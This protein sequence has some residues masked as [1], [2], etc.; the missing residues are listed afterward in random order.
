MILE[1]SAYVSI[2]F[3]LLPHL[4]F[5]WPSIRLNAWLIVVVRSLCVEGARTATVQELTCSE[6]LAAEAENQV[7]WGPVSLGWGIHSSP[8]DYS[9]QSH[10]GD[11]KLKSLGLTPR[12][13]DI[14]HILP[15]T[16][17]FRGS[18]FKNTAPP[19]GALGDRVW[20]WALKVTSGVVSECRLP[21]HRFI[22][23]FE[24]EICISWTALKNVLY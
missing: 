2:S 13:S 15:I 23:P 16:V 20:F 5:L 14:W 7:A 6:V 9:L 1:E 21:P 12:L 4:V 18:A 22:G 19:T 17:V 8:H 11:L 10:R 3:L 24:I